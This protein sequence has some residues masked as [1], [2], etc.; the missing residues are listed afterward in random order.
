MNF[1][2]SYQTE[3]AKLEKLIKAFLPLKQKDLRRKYTFK[4]KTDI[5]RRTLPTNE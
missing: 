4:A 1:F 2:V 5:Y 3:T